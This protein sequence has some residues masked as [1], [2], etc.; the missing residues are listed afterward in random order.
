MILGGLATVLI[1][2]KDFGDD[3]YKVLPGMLV[4][5]AIYAIS[6]LTIRARP[7]RSS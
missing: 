4:P 3:F 5:F 1:W 2:P 7:K 6:E